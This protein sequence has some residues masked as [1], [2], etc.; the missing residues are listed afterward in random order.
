MTLPATEFG[1]TVDSDGKFCA[2]MNTVPVAPDELLKLT[3]CNC[4]KDCSTMRCSCKNLGV[5]C[6]AACWTCH[7]ISCSNAEAENENGD[8]DGDDLDS[9]SDID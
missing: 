8:D 9:Y 7:G 1:W 3:A 2:V 6:I 5:K 4:K